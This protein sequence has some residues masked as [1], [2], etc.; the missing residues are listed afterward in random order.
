MGQKVYFDIKGAAEY[1]GVRRLTIYNWFRRGSHVNGEVV[2]LPV[3]I[4]DGQTLINEIDLNNHLDAL[5]Y[6]PAE[7]AEENNAPT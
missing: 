5:G 1:A 2:F 6:G 4:I 7:E 3:R